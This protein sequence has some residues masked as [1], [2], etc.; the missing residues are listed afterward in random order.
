MK[1]DSSS[2]LL[3]AVTD[4]TWLGTA[5]LAEQAEACLKGGVT[6]IQLRE[7]ELHSSEFLKE[8]E[9]IKAL[10]HQYQVPFLINDNVEIALSCDADG[11]HVGQKDMEAGAVR[12]KLGSDK[13]LG[14][15]V[16][17][18]EQALA[19]EENG[20]DYLGTGAVFTTSTKPDANGVSRSTLKAICHAVSIPVVA[21][22]GIQEHNILTLKGTGIQGAAVISAIF[23]KANIETAA[24]RL[25]FLSKEMVQPC[26]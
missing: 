3:Y 22:G 19:A 14:V 9:E 21:I 23:S 24:K 13:I 7:K 15:S 6:M 8:A 17:T 1:F 20:A 11:V 5:T 25:V 4:R 26:I 10:C 2:L 18:V 12:S 16:Q